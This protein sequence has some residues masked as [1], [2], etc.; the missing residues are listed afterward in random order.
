MG[1]T[2]IK[3]FFFLFTI[4]VATPTTPFDEVANIVACPAFLPV[5]NPLPSTVAIDLLL[6]LHVR[7][8]LDAYGG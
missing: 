5:T 4:T 6:L 2:I 7:V 3:V 8:L 1:Y